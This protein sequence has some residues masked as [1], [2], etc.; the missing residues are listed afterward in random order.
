MTRYQG[1]SSGSRNSMTTSPL[2][3]RNEEDI[4]HAYEELAATTRSRR[5]SPTSP[6]SSSTMS[7]ATISSSTISPRRSAPP[8]SRRR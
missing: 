5:R 2:T 4:I 1:T 3:R 8:L 7:D 6:A